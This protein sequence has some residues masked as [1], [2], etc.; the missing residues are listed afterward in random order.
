MMFTFCLAALKKGEILVSA[1][2]EVTPRRTVIRAQVT[3]LM[4]NKRHQI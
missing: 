2:E 4:D 3:T 1:I